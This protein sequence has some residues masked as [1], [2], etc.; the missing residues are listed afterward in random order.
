MQQGSRQSS[1][2]GVPSSH[3][4]APYVTPRTSLN[5]EILKWLL[6]FVAA[7]CNTHLQFIIIL[8]SRS[9]SASRSLSRGFVAM[10]FQACP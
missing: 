8:S 3:E 4:G 10:V 5:S 7:I 2:E 6:V 1:F 9:A